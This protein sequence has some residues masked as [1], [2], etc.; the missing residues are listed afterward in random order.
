M[1]RFTNYDTFNINTTGVTGVFKISAGENLTTA[2]KTVNAILIT[3]GVALTG[4]QC[5]MFANAGKPER[6]RQQHDLGALD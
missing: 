4:N 3:G 6:W 5:L 1:T 2:G